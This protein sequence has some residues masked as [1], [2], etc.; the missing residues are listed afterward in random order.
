MGAGRGIKHKGKRSRLE[1]LVGTYVEKEGYKHE[2]E[3][4]RYV[5]PETKKYYLPDF[6][7]GDLI[8]EAK[9]RFTAADRKKMILVQEQH[10]DLA[11]LMVFGRA[12]NKLSKKSKTTY[13]D[14]CTKNNLSWV[15]LEDF[16][17]EHD[18]ICQLL[19]T[20][21]KIFGKLPTLPMK[22]EKA[23]SK[24]PPTKSRTSSG[25]KRRGKS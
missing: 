20:K 12:D 9:G 16:K 23:S 19:T 4:V 8:V 11:I 13:G 17:K 15:D 5:F 25:R 24:S 14:W 21:E 18:K 1:A 2:P 6:K 10:P 3:K 7:K 22:S